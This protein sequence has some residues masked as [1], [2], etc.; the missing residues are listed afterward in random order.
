VE[1][2]AGFGGVG[3]GVVVGA[4]AACVG[5]STAAVV[6]DLVVAAAFGEALVGLCE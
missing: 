5:S 4:V 3:Q 2:G 6:G 1:G